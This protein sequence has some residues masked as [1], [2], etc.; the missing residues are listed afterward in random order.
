MGFVVDE[1][2]PVDD[3]LWVMGPHAASVPTLA[4]AV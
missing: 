2:Q 3:H 1:V 4:I